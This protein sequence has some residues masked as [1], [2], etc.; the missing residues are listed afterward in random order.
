MKN[1]IKIAVKGSCNYQLANRPGKAIARIQTADQ[2]IYRTIEAEGSTVVRLIIQILLE[3][4]QEL[5]EPANIIL[6]SP[7]KIGLQKIKDKQGHYKVCS[8]TK[9][10]ADLLNKLQEVLINGGHDIVEI[11]TDKY[12]QL[13]K[14]E[15]R[16]INNNR[17]LA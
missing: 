6:Y 8:P 9:T 3:T 4:I 11:E 13:L 5:S 14:Q 1:T 12:K 16:A 2:V 10:N 15:A 17:I 7:N